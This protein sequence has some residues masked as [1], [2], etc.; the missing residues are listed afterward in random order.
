MT[1]ADCAALAEAIEP[2][3]AGTPATAAQHAHLAECAS[4]RARLALAVRLERVLAEWPS[5]APAPGLASR[6]LEATR[7]EAWHREQVV[8][9]SFNIAIAA[10]L[11][12]V[13]VGLASLVWLLGAAAGPVTSTQ[14]VTDAAATFLARVRGQVMVLATAALLLTTTLGAWWW[15]EERR[16]W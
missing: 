3:A 2:M 8:D 15:A 6:V 5:P 12:A 1:S 11:V 9:W 14:V 16:D 4:C 7:R 13:L 10:G